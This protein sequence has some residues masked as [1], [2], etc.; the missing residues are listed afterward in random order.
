M[1]SRRQAGNVKVL[2]Q[3]L[4]FLETLCN[5]LDV[6]LAFK[7][8]P[9]DVFGECVVRVDRFELPP[10]LAC[11]FELTEMTQRRG[12]KGARK[13]RPGHEHNSLPERSGRC[14]VLSRKQICHTKEV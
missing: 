9:P 14:F 11:L 8:L 6:F 10:N 5:A 1:I 3:Q 12:Q 13:I 2:V 4:R 7:G